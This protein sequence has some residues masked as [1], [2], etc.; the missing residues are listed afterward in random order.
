MLA[1]FKEPQKTVTT[2][3]EKELRQD[4]WSLKGIID[5]QAEKIK[6]LESNSKPK[7]DIYLKSELNRLKQLYGTL[8]HH[9]NELRAKQNSES[10]S[11]NPANP[12]EI[13]L[14]V[15]KYYGITV[16]QIL[17]RSRKKEIKN[18]RHIVCYILTKRGY[19]LSTVG[20]IMGRDHSTIINSRDWVI[21]NLYEMPESDKNFINNFLW[22]HK[23]KKS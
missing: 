11:I 22:C 3:T 1:I 7:E 23:T 10:F 14:E 5:K 6:Q 16:T 18:P 21:Y 15:S 8:L 4:N 12:D 19:S 2:M 13:L 17:G 9:Y 20:K